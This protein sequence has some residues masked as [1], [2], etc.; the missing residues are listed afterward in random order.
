MQGRRRAKAARKRVQGSW[1]TT[2]GLV[3]GT[4]NSRVAG[5]PNQ[6]AAGTEGARP[7]AYP[8][9]GHFCETTQK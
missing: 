2:C 7:K 3:G 1:G 5:H 8:D 9:M 4:W 6:D